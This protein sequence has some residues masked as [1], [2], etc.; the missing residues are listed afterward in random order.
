MSAVL[1]AVLGLVAE[2]ALWCALVVAVAAVISLP[3][4]FLLGTGRRRLAG[5]VHAAIGAALAVGIAAR[6]GLPDLWRLGIEA[7]QVTVV[8]AAVGAL[9]TTLGEAIIA[10]R[11]S[12]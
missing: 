3:L 9:A 7:R 5:M 2:T 10:R 6:A 11:R 1:R 12:A 8:W 4:S